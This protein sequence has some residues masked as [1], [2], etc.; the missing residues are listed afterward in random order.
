MRT[1]VRVLVLA[2]EPS[3]CWRRVPPLRRRPEGVVNVSTGTFSASL[4]GDSHIHAVIDLPHPC[5]QPII[6]VA[7]PGGQWFAESNPDTQP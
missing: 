4:T 5:K 2:I 3:A 1:F 7:A 6:F